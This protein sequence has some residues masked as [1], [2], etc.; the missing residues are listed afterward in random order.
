MELKQ[1]GLQL[2]VMAKLNCKQ[3]DN[4]VCTEEELK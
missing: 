4:V 2:K 1:I 3:V